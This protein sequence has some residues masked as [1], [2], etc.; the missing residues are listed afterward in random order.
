MPLGVEVEAGGGLTDVYTRFVLESENKLVYSFK[1]VMGMVR[2]EVRMFVDDTDRPAMKGFLMCV[3][4][5]ANTL[6]YYVLRVPRR[7]DRWR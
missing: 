6:H 4:S 1:L 7:V 2:D 3:C 5:N